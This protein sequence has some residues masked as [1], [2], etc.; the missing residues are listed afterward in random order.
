M[1]LFLI[2]KKVDFLMLSVVSNISIFGEL[3]QW[4][5][6]ANETICDIVYDRDLWFQ[7]FDVLFCFFDVIFNFLD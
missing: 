2:N 4:K 6:T 5:K 1:L 3:L 7:F